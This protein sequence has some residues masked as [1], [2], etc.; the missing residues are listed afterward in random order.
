MSVCDRRSLLAVVVA[1]LVLGLALVMLAGCPVSESI[2]EVE[3]ETG[4][5][6]GDPIKFD[7][8]EIPDAPCTPL[9]EPPK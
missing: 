8:L 6:F 2:V 1:E 3:D 7:V 4:D 9:P 5:D